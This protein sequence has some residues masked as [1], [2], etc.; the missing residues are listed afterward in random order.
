MSQFATVQEALSKRWKVVLHG[1]ENFAIYR[2]EDDS[3]FTEDDKEVVGCSEWMRAEG[4]VLQHIV[5][6]HNASVELW[7][8]KNFKKDTP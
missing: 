3:I 5:S 4:E 1:E 2:N 8:S 6:L 7:D